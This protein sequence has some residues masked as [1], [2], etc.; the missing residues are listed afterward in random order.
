MATEINFIPKQ[1][2]I[3]FYMAGFLFRQNPQR[4]IPGKDFV[5]VKNTVELITPRK[6]VTCNKEMTKGELTAE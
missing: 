3:H 4:F 6:I 2:F 1:N 5:S